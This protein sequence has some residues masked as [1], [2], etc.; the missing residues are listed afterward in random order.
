M[1]GPPPEDL[2]RDKLLA[3]LRR[4]ADGRPVLGDYTLLRR[5]GVGGM[6]AVYYGLHPRLKREVAIKILPFHL[7]DQE[8]ELVKRF[9]AEARMAASR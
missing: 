6:G 3:T 7:V 1:A 8:P 2:S 5:I 9:L 4:D